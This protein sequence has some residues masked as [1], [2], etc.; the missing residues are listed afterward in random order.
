LSFCV[1]DAAR[2]AGA[3]F[4]CLDPIRSWKPLNCDRMSFRVVSY[5]PE[6]GSSLS[7]SSPEYTTRHGKRKNRHTGTD[8]DSSGRK[9][10][11]GNAEGRADRLAVRAQWLVSTCGK[12]SSYWRALSESNLGVVCAC[13]HVFR[14]QSGWFVE[15]FR[16]INEPGAIVCCLLYDEETEERNSGGDGKEERNSGGVA[17]NTINE[18]D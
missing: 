14:C 17:A 9:D 1:F 5:F 4:W 8:C 2:K 3:I 12:A 7:S 6:F 18:P 10:R 11:R 16:S 15:R 13:V